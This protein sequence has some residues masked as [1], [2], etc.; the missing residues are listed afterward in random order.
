MMLPDQLSSRHA[1]H[2]IDQDRLIH[3]Y[4]VRVSIC[5]HQKLTN[6]SGAG[7]DYINR[8]NSSI[9][10][11]LPANEPTLVASKRGFLPISSKIV[12]TAESLNVFPFLLSFHNHSCTVALNRCFHRCLDLT[13]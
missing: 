3:L 6:S 11:L 9:T 13:P 2:W 12:D 8:S 10:W 7:E 1:H 5:F 4:G